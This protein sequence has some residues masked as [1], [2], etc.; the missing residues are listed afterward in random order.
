MTTRSDI[1]HSFNTALKS[2]RIRLDETRE[3]RESSDPE[4]DVESYIK[5]IVEDIKLMKSSV[6]RMKDIDP[7]EAD[8]LEDTLNII[9]YVVSVS[10]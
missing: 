3:P 8:S 1:V 4:F 7:D 10:L 6:D 5:N 2:I 9:A